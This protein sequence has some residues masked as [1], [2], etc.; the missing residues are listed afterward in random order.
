LVAFK[1][2]SGNSPE[3]S[4]ATTVIWLAGF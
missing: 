3:R 1:D 4:S 2:C